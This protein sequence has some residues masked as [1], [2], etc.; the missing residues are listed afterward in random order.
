[1]MIGRV[2]HCAQLG[3]DLDAVE[4]GQAEIEDDQIGLA[5]GGLD[6]AGA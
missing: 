1:M 6:Q 3:D 5:R 4:V 2:Y